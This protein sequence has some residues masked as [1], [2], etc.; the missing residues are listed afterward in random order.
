M[1]LEPPLAAHVNATTDHFDQPRIPAIRRSAMQRPAALL[2]LAAALAAAAPAAAAAAAARAGGW[3][4]ALL[5]RLDAGD[6]P[7][8]APLVGV[9]TQP[10]PSR[11]A[12]RGRDDWHT[13]S[14]PLV[15]W[16]AAAGARVAPI[17]F[18]APW[19]EVDAVLAAVDA[20]VLP[21]GS[22]ELSP[23]HPFYDTA[24][25]ATAAARAEAAAGGVM[26]VFG[27]CLGFELLH[28]LAANRSRAELL[29][30]SAGQEGVT[31][32]LEL[33]PAAKGSLFFQR[34]SRELRAEAAAPAAALA[35]NAHAWAVPPAAYAAH[36]E[37]A[38]AFDILS[39]SRD[40]DG[41]E[42][43]STVEGAALPWFGTQW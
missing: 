23:G 39:T 42:Y 18:D 19:A 11:V 6:A 38:E 28:L 14:G 41:V 2:L 22:G 37:L 34:W 4:A 31:A 30:A 15:S 8:P 33:T 16:L 9:L 12:H 13:V 26:P 43:I 29:E 20:L 7:A 24:E 32:P 1:T 25:R 17:R 27:V 36:P 10:A 40:A 3:R 35:F 21:G 5:A